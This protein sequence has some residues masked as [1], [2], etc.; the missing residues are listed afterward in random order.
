[1][2]TKIS[3]QPTYLNA[4]YATISATNT[5]D[6]SFTIDALSDLTH[7]KLLRSNN[8]GGPFSVI[9]TINT[10]N[11]HITYADNIPFLSGIYYYMLE[12]INNCGASSGQSNLANNIIL[13]GTLSGNNV[14]LAW[15]EYADWAGGVENYR[16]IRS[17]GHVN[18]VTD[19][20]NAGTQT[21]YTDNISG[22]VDYANPASSYICYR[23]EAVEH[24]NVYGIQGR[25]FS[26]QVCFSVTPDIRMPNA[27]IPND[28]EPV[29][30]VFEPVFSFLPERYQ[31]IIYNRLGTRLWE[32][33]GPWDGRVAGKYVPEGVYLYL[34]RVYNYSTDILE[35]N[36]KV[37]V[38]YR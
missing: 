12:V 25:S 4:D 1:V 2:Y 33:F 29:N 8:R 17:R 28:N 27:F 23:I 9:D 31:L 19:T 34:L 3:Q 32:G 26:N 5:I 22:L 35:L 24:I 20:L 30:Q 14:S 36:G 6:L 13:S 18:P 15:N 11:S 38:L 10:K 16:I 21:N 7:Y 37:T